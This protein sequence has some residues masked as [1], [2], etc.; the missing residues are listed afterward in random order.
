VV[1]AP[2]ATAFVLT[3]A[4][5]NIEGSTAFINSSK[6]NGKRSIKLPRRA[7]VTLDWRVHGTVDSARLSDGSL[8]SDDGRRTEEKASMTTIPADAPR[9]EDGQWWWDGAQWQPVEPDAPATG[10]E[11]NASGVPYTATVDIPA[12]TEVGTIDMSLSEIED[13]LTAAGVDLGD[14]SGGGD[15]VAQNPNE[16]NA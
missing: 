2:T 13:I 12:G 15:L 6:T 9:S 1:P 14:S 8:P 10:G 16:E 3:S 4:S 5:S 11:I 7:R